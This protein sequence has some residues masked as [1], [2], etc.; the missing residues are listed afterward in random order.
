MPAAL[1]ELQIDIDCEADLTLF[2][3]AWKNVSGLGLLR[4]ATYSRRPSPSGRAGRWHIEVRLAMPIDHES[5]IALQALLGSDRTREMLSWCRLQRG[6]ALPVL[7]F[8]RPEVS[9]ALDPPGDSPLRRLPS[10]IPAVEK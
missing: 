2:E 4:G 3:G 10:V 8:E 6:E 9:S 5:R 7:F 1:N